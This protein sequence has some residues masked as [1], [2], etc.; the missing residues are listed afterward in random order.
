MANKRMSAKEL[1]LPLST[2]AE[3]QWSTKA[4]RQEFFLPVTGFAWFYPEE[5]DV[6][7]HPAF[8]RLARINQLGQAHLVF[9][10]ATHKRIEHVLGAVCIAQRMISAVQFNAEKAKAKGAHRSIDT[11]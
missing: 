6:I 2:Q 7:N 8:Q 9:R 4:D 1:V 11:A 3:D 5:V 10:G